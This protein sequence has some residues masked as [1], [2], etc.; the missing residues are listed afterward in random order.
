MKYVVVPSKRFLKRVQKHRKSGRKHILRAVAEV[1]ELLSVHDDR[2]LYVLG[3]RWK[4]H[5]LQGD[6]H[7]IRELHLSQDDLLLYEFDEQLKIV[8]LLDIVSHEE[9]RKR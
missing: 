9:L 6:K 4:D 2:S 1:I 5:A 8:K 3:T 7:G